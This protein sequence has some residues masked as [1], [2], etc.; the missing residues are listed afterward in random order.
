MDR[1]T[2]EKE[3]ERRINQYSVGDSYKPDPIK[4]SWI[5]PLVVGTVNEKGKEGRV[6]RR[7][8][9]GNCDILLKKLESITFSFATQCLLLKV[10]D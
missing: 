10:T 6:K 8:D 3:L 9:R 4:K 2:N 7:Q 1:T 5:L